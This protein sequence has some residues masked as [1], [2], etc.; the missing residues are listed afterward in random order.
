MNSLIKV[1][2]AG[3]FAVLVSSQAN[4][5]T[6]T[7]SSSGVF[8]INAPGNNDCSSCSGNNTNVLGMSG[9]SGISTLTATPTNFSVNTNTDNTPIGQLVWVNN[10]TS[11][12]SD[13]NTNFDVTYRFSLS[14]SAPG[15]SNTADTQD[16]TLNIQQTVNAAGDLIFNLTNAT[17]QNLNFTL[18]GV[19]VS[20]LH[21]GLAA[22]SF[23]QYYT[24]NGP[25]VQAGEWTNPEN[26]TST[27]NIYA[28]FTAVAGVPEP[29]TWAMMILG[30]AGVGFM[31]YRR[32]THSSFRLV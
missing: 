24:S 30:F 4:A 9:T 18:N 27:L 15:G 23:G 2:A 17:L 1:A 26:R 32:K 3:L 11:G 29:S 19:T 7:G 28:D 6:V 12:V 14:F 8:L 13:A 16:F 25:G 5:V 22:G 20:D 31:A 21:F 10:E